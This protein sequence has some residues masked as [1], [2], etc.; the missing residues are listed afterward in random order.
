[1]ADRCLL[2]TWGEVARGREERAVE[3][4]NETVGYYGRAQQEGRIESFDTVLCSPNGV[5]DGYIKVEGTAQQL[6]A[7]KE[8]RE[9]QRI[10]AEAGT[11]V[12]DLAITDAVCN[13]GVADQMEIFREAIA[14][15]PQ[16]A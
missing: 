16:M 8:D 2:T 1:M 9:F 11:I 6:A 3:C 7:M 13:Q 10:M 5:L 15:V 12:D 14:K 4:F